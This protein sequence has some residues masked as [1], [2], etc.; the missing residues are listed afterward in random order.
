[1]YIDVEIK[2]GINKYT[3]QPIVPTRVYVFPTINR[4]KGK[5]VTG[6]MD[7]EFFNISADAKG[8]LN[9]MI[10]GYDAANILIAQ[11]SIVVPT[12][13]DGMVKTSRNNF[14]YL[15]DWKYFA[16]NNRFE[17]VKKSANRDIGDDP[18]NGPTGPD[19]GPGPDIITYYC[20]KQISKV[21]LLIFFSEFLEL[22]P[23]EICEFKL[24]YETITTHSWSQGSAVTLW[25]EEYCELLY[26]FYDK[27]KETNR[28]GDECKCK[29]INSDS[30]V[31]HSIGNGTGTES[32]DCPDVSVIEGDEYW[33]RHSNPASKSVQNWYNILWGYMGAAKSVYLNTRM[34]G[35]HDEGKGAEKS[36]LSSTLKS[37]ISYL[38]RCYD[39]KQATIDSTCNC[40]KN[41]TTVAQYVSRGE[42]YAFTDGNALGI[43]NGKVKSC[44]NDFAFFFRFSNEGF[45]PI[46]EG[47]AAICAECESSDTTNFFTNLGDLASGIEDLAPTF[48]GGF[49][50]SKVDDYLNAAGNVYDTFKN[51]FTLEPDCHD[52][53]DTIYYLINTSDNYTLSGDNDF[54]SYMMTSSYNLKSELINDEAESTVH[55]ISDYYLASVL[56]SN[57]DSICCAETLAS[58][59]IGTLSEFQNDNLGHSKFSG[60]FQN[61]P[62]GLAR[63]QR[64]VAK[65][66]FDLSAGESVDIL[67]EVFNI[68]WCCTADVKC[69]YQC[70]YYGDCN[71]RNLI[72]EGLKINLNN[73]III[74]NDILNPDKIHYH[75]YPNPILSDESLTIEYIS[76]P[77]LIDILQLIREDGKIVFS[78]NKVDF[79]NQ[80]SHTINL[81]N[82][83][84]GVYYLNLMS[85]DRNTTKMV[86]IK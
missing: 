22:T 73:N 60:L 77:I 75:V 82:L 64:D 9:L 59:S 1:M 25:N 21:E 61:A 48:I 38:M 4:N 6:D 46:E 52:S 16:R 44:I 78:K 53:K 11:K 84:P 2:P 26:E 56:K 15:F 31:D 41:I 47:A 39:P 83:A 63:M 50:I 85:K 27:Y 35:N 86:I 49:D 62:V 43:G 55:V 7:A 80:K 37:S 42:A 69:Y 17:D 70:G 23:Q 67:T 36:E 24:L 57:G 76:G 58:Y 5:W 14:K 33:G 13:K 66:F 32:E 54:V 71:E 28:G 45:E 74:K 3:K 29:V 81:P 10:E 65:I 34:W 40:E 68:D 72:G 51:I 30:F 19:Q 18:T 79:Q 8:N 12:A 20:G